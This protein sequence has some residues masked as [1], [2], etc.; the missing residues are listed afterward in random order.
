MIDE[1]V[2]YSSEKVAS[3]FRGHL[4]QHARFLWYAAQSGTQCTCILIFTL[5]FYLEVHI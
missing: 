2:I 1:S 4:Y 3:Y 5:F